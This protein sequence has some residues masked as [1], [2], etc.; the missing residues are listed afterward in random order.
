MTLELNHTNGMVV[1]TKA[2]E[3]IEG[4][5]MAEGTMATGEKEGV[6]WKGEG[7]EK[8]SEKRS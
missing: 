1:F 8:H 4:T 6:L 3:I 7:E 2:R 5:G